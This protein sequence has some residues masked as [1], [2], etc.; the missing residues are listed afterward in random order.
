MPSNVHATFRLRKQHLWNNPETEAVRKYIFSIEEAQRSG[1][2][3]KSWRH[4]GYKTTTG[5]TF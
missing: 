2:C 1:T 5:T 3:T 4:S